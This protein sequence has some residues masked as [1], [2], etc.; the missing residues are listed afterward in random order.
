MVLDI[1]VVVLDPGLPLPAYARPG[2]AGADLVARE[3]AVVAAGGG[4]ALIP[5]GISV[6][7]PEGYAGFVQP[8]SGL[9]WRHGITLANS[10]GLI[11]A[12]YR[13]E[14]AVIVIN[15]DPKA[16]FEVR[17][18]RPDRA[19]GDPAGGAGGL[20]ARRRSSPLGAGSR[21]LRPH[22][23]VAVPELPEVEAL[24]RFLGDACSGQVIER[25]EVAA[26]SAL[27]TYDPPVESLR[28]LTISGVERRGKYLVVSVGDRFLVMHLARGGWV[29]WRDQAPPARAKPGK[30]PLAL[31]VGLSG[32]GGFDVTEQGTEKRLAIWVVRDPADVEGIARLGPDPLDP[33]MTVDDLGEL[34]AGQ[35]GNLK[36]VLADQSVLSGVGNAY[37]D[38]ILHAARHVAVQ[39]GQ[40]TRPTTK[41][42]PS[43]PP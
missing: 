34:L 23:A 35:P 4:R 10:P 16:D 11:D 40:E 39:T 1:P 7:I 9:A 17:R 19:A 24:C 12:G 2:D 5:T 6:A 28:G 41:S 22:R 3:D 26:L 21:W 33:P 20:R 29:Q 36:T 25:A 8:R 43:T 18:G 14:L 30:G 42:S 38:E 13:D 37:S 15:T 27:K 31:R 32:G